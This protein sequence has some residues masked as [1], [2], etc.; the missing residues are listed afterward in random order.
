MLYFL[1]GAP[2]A[3]KSAISRQF[4]KETETPFF[5]LDYLM[6]GFANGLPA[7]GVDP[8]DDELAVGERLW[9]VV[10]PMAVALLEDEVEHPDQIGSER[11]AVQPRYRQF[12]LKPFE[13]GSLWNL[14]P[15][16]LD[17]GFTAMYRGLFEWASAGAE[18]RARVMAP[19]ILR[20]VTLRNY[21][22][23]WGLVLGAF[24]NDLACQLFEALA[25]RATRSENLDQHDNSFQVARASAARSNRCNRMTSNATKP[26]TGKASI[27]SDAPSTQAP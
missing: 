7:L 11:V 2:R 8:E 6:M 24:G 15:D 3:G 26:P 13:T 22:A 17:M 27:H 9:P 23:R 14:E 18:V 20:G 25:F 12:N 19:G 16:S 21:G 4:L 1:G 5:C 10:K